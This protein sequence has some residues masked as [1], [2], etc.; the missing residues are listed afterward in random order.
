MLEQQGLNRVGETQHVVVVKWIE[1]GMTMEDQ[2]VRNREK[3]RSHLKYVAHSIV[4]NGPLVWPTV[5]QED[6]T[7]RKKMYAELSA[8][9]KIQ[10]DCDLKAINIVL[11][12]LPP[13]VYAIINHHKDEKEGQKK[14]LLAQVQ[15]AG[16]ALSM[17]QLAILADIGDRVD[18]LPDCDDI[19][20]A[21]AVLMANLSSYDSDVLSDV[22]HSE[23]YKNDMDN[24]SVQAM[25][26]FEQTPIVDFL[27][28]EITSDSNTITLNIDLNTH[29]KMIDSQVDDMIKEKHALKQQIDSLE[30]NLSNQ[31]KEKESL[32]QTFTIFKNESKEKE[33]KYMDK[34]IDLEKKIKELDNIVYKVGQSAQTVHMLTKPQVF[35]DDTHKQA[36]GYQNPFYHKKA[37]WIKP[38]L[39]DGSVISSQHDVIPV[40]DEEETLILEELQTLHPN[41]DQSATSPVKIEALRELPKVSLVVS[42]KKL[43]S[44][45]SKFDT[46][47][48][49]RITPDVI[50]EGEWGFEHTKD[51][52]LKEIIPFL[53]TLKDIFNIFD[54]D[55]LNK[56]FFWKMI[57]SYKKTMYR[58]VLLFV[59]NSTTLNG[60]S[61]NFEMQ[62]SES[63]DKCFDLDAELSKIQNSYNELLKK[64]FENND[65][66]AQLQAKD[67]TI[68]KLKDHKSM[69][70]NEKEEKVKHDMDEIETINI[71]LE[72]SHMFTEI[73]YKWK[74]IGRLFTLVGN[75]CP[76]TRITPTK[77]VPIKESTSHSVETQKPEHKVY[78]MK[79][80]QVKSEGC[81]DYSL[82][83]GY[84]DYQLGN[85]IVSRVY[86]VEG[87][88]HNLF[89]VGQ[90]CD[91]DLEVAFRKNTCFIRNLEG[92]DLLSGSR[93]TNLYT[94]SLD[95]MLKT[96]LISKDGLARGIP[97][98]K[99]KKDHLCSACAL[100][101]GKKSSHQPKVEDT[102]QEKLYLLHMD[103]CGPMH[104]ESINGKNNGIEFV[105]QTLREFYENVGISHQTFVAHT[106][107]QNG[108]VK[109]RNRTL[110]EATRT[111]LIF[112]KAL[113][114]LWAEAINT[115]CYTQNR[116]LICLRY[117]KTPY[118]LMHDKK[119]NLLFL[120][121]FG[122]LCYLTNDSENLGKLNAKVDTGIFVV[123]APTKK[124]FRIYNRRTRKIMETIHVTFNE[125]TAMAF[126]QF[127]SRPELQSMTPVTSSSGLV[128]NLI[129]QLPVQFQTRNDWDCLF[130][131]MFD[132]YFNPPQSVI[133]PV[134][135]AVAP[136]AVDIADSLSSTTIDL[137]ALLKYFN[138]LTNK[139]N[140]L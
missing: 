39:Y 3:T 111:M 106:P 83:M 89:L 58:D 18:S 29:E 59:M 97:K 26:N 123:Y 72:H 88:G 43:K 92:V 40:I 73:G 99:I 27:D 14:M 31:I 68:C 11:Q 34:E 15:E 112:S 46:V 94:I 137:D 2:I 121:V 85:V 114:F 100:G 37:Q 77:V 53:T 64:Y 44:H 35:Y 135:V 54:R 119:P 127:S 10:S 38:T 130:Q 115:A 84:G 41:T 51:I 67:I 56:N 78:S 62:R 70:E 36:L 87:L 65:L 129:P 69:R 80:K 75:S 136:R 134:P 79:P 118:D 93:D 50:T 66:K 139:N 120:H 108:V 96:S 124:A 42:L 61:E 109:R 32:L 102:N 24:Q 74:S 90:F 101:K 126:E 25:L 9:K 71:E 86:Y 138:H 28:N 4:L 140:N 133:S 8:T 19:S 47:M 55:L 21:K 122:S 95:D 49:K 60:E 1:M 116:S 98:L 81:P 48:K 105:N 110:V 20:T 5:V 128:S 52:F 132:E 63:C 45:L 125:L 76:L 117:N 7:T 91:A 30:Q 22:P 33:S 107:Q 82:I 12:G 17:E 23:I 6:G 104:V 113:L 13:D 57:D 103:L 131:P 16:I